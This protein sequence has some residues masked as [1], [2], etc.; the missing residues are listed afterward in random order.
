MEV[1][2]EVWVEEVW[3]EEVVEVAVVE[4]K[5]GGF[6]LGVVLLSFL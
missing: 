3:A 4:M 1:A 2:A 5:M 6:P